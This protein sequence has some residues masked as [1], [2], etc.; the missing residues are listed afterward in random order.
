MSFYRGSREAQQ[1][2]KRSINYHS[3]VLS[4]K[5]AKE[6]GGLLTVILAEAGIQ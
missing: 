2:P 5:F 3:S 4:Q 6:V 1:S